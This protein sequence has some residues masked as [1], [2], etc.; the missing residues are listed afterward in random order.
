VGA[1]RGGDLRQA[2][3]GKCRFWAGAEQ[4]AAETRRFSSN[5]T[6]ARTLHWDRLHPIQS[7]ETFRR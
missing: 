2:T 3:R 7:I 1:L 6:T 4:A 5:L